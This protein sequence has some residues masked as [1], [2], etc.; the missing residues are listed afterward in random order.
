MCEAHRALYVR[1]VRTRHYYYVC[2]LRPVSDRKRKALFSVLN[3]RTIMVTVLW[4]SPGG[5]GG[6]RYQPLKS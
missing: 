3:C 6:S 1:Y 5:G 2:R 4:V